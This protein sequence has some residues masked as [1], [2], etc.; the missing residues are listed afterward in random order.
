LLND[1]HVRVLSA[2]HTVSA[3]VAS[4]GLLMQ[5]LASVG[6]VP[7]KTPALPAATVTTVEKL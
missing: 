5:L 6:S 3:F 1:A 7:G 2:A 4:A